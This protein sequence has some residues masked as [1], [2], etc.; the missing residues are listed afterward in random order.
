MARMAE[1]AKSSPNMRAFEAIMNCSARTCST[2]STMK[3][4][5]VHW[6]KADGGCEKKRTSPLVYVGGA[7]KASSSGKKHGCIFC[8]GGAEGVVTGR[9]HSLSSRSCNR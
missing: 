9:V 7:S 5:G 2:R 6:E 8:E 3:G 4:D 1:S